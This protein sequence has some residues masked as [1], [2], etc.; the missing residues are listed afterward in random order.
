MTMFLIY[1]IET[2]GMIWDKFN[3]DRILQNTY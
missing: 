1:I 3:N 2:W